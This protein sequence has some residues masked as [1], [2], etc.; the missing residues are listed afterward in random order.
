M[1]I[2]LTITDTQDTATFTVISSPL[3][4]QPIIAETD[5]TTVDNN[6]STY[7]TGSKKRYTINLG[8]MDKE[9]Y[10]VLAG[11]RD[12]QYANLKYPTITITGDE[13]INVNNMTAKMT[14]S[15]QRVVNNCGEVSEVEVSFRESKQLQ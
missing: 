1:A 2:Q 7:Y 3:I 6:I 10:A 15:E 14:L 5:V 12:R 13:N 4:S 11:F 8:Y 9:T